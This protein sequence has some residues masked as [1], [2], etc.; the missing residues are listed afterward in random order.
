MKGVGNSKK[1]SEVREWDKPNLCQTNQLTTK[2]FQFP[3]SVFGPF[4]LQLEKINCYCSSTT[5]L[6]SCKEQKL[7]TIDAV[8]TTTDAKA[9]IGVWINYCQW[10]GKRR[11]A[12][13]QILTIWNITK[14]ARSKD[15]FVKI[16]RKTKQYKN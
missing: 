2:L 5:T 6:N 16:G 8:V 9:N 1:V 10:N 14:S 13:S 12:I 3:N 15:P 4:R 11:I 7:E